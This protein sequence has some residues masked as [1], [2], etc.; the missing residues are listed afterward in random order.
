[1]KFVT[2]TTTTGTQVHERPRSHPRRRVP[3]G[4][5]ATISVW[6]YFSCRRRTQKYLYLP[7]GPLERKTHS[8]KV[9]R[10]SAREEQPFRD[11]PFAHLLCKA[12]TRIYG[13][14]YTGTRSRTKQTGSRDDWNGPKFGYEVNRA[15]IQHYR[16]SESPTNNRGYIARFCCV[17]KRQH[18]KHGFKSTKRRT[19]GSRDQILRRNN[20]I[21]PNL[22]SSGSIFVAGRHFLEN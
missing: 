22:P 15:R 16:A 17:N 2:E 12:E 18:A 1:M 8:M 14:F 9:G 19:L 6:R 11:P 21:W 3:S 7:L 10:P 20:P 13:L 4:Y 5:S